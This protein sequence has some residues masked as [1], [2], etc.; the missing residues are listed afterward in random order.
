M[1]EWIADP[2]A[3]ISLATLAALEIVLGIDNIIFINILVGRL[4]ERQRQSGRI[5]GL[6]LAMLTRIL[7]LMSLAWIMKLTAPLFTVFN[8]EI[9]GRDLILLIGGLFLI[10]KSFGEIKEAINH[11]EHHN[12]ESKNKVSYF[13]VLIQIAVLDIVFS[14]DSVITAV[15][16]AS[17]LPVMILAIIIAVGVMMFAAKPIGAFVDTH[18]TLKILALAF[19][20]LVGISLIAESLDIHIPKGYI[21]FAMGFSVVVEMINIRMRRLIK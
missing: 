10:I 13:G 15:G 3:W 9:S 19:L 11:Q 14:L 18:P 21:Y 8:Q 1:F 7:L 5:L 16:M 2:E 17:H 4:P 20:V 12:S 6:A